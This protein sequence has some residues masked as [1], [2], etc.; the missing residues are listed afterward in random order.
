MGTVVRTQTV[1]RLG[2]RGDHVQGRHRTS[3][4]PD[5]L[6]RL[7]AAA[8][9][10]RAES[11]HRTV[12]SDSYRYP[13][14]KKGAQRLEDLYNVELGQMRAVVEG[15]A[16]FLDGASMAVQVDLV[17]P[18]QGRPGHG[19]VRGPVQPPFV[20]RNGRRSTVSPIT[21]LARQRKLML[22]YAAEHGMAEAA[23]SLGVSRSWLYDLK[24]GA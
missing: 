21:S 4:M 3:P 20:V 5:N 22:D 10:V 9:R 17:R 2:C 18:A 8:R 23:R 7:N 12:K 24:G 13:V 16:G 15:L 11:R 1:R 19:G 6:Q 14:D